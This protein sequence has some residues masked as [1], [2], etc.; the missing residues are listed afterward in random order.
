MGQL[1]I[2]CP[3]TGKYMPVGIEIDAG[4]FSNSMFAGNKSRCPHC[5]EMQ[6]LEWGHLK[7]RTAAVDHSLPEAERIPQVESAWYVCRECGAEIEEGHQSTLLCHLGNIAYRTGRA[8]RL[9]PATHQI[10]GDDEARALWTRE[11]QKGWE[12]RV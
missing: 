5:G 11:Y 8:V 3:R 12:P 4:S 1:M 7:Y 9:D 10:V 2:K 6:P